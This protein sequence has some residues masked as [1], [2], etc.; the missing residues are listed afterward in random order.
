MKRTA[1]E[2]PNEPARYWMK[3]VSAAYLRML[4]ATQI[5]A[6]KAVGRNARTI[7]EWEAHETWPAAREAARRLWLVDLSDASRHALLQT[8]RGGNGDLALKVLERIDDELRPPTHRVAPTDPTG[9]KPYEPL[10]DAERVA[11]L[12]AI[13]D[14]AR[15]RRSESSPD[16]GG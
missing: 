5:D 6:A 3:R 12:M 14:H 10:D 2:V 16:T 9:Q 13:L 1:F 4:G 7:R 8:I 11:R 15:A